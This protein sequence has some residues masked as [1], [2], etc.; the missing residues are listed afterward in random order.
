MQLAAFRGQLDVAERLG[1]PVVVHARDADAALAELIEAYSGRVTGVLHCFSG[2]A[3]LLRTGIE[4]GWYVSFA[5]IV[6]FK[7]YDGD[8]LV[9]RVPSDRLLVE[10]DSPYLAPVPRRG[11]RNEPAFV[12]HVLR[13]VASI[14]GD[15]A[16]D[17]AE[18]THRNACRF[19]GLEPA[20]AGR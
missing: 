20:D 1:L 14:R 3:A 6:T 10:T 5:G 15:D 18:T 17:L 12:E 8:E 4:A 2:G 7:N 19:Y 16:G 13:H 9:R 11:K